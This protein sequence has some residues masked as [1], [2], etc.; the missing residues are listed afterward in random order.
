MTGLRD[1]Y[2]PTLRCGL[3]QDMS[4]RCRYAAAATALA[5]GPAPDTIQALDADQSKLR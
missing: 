4:R 1:G 2:C 3:D 5:A